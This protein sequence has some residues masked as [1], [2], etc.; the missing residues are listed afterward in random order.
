M[1][2]VTSILAAVMMIGMMAGPAW[3]Q[4]GA[5]LGPEAITQQLRSDDPA[6]VQAAVAAI[7][8]LVERQPAVVARADHRSKV[9]TADAW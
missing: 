2:C 3:G 5:S 1:R 6:E 8:D 4:E 9:K 7:R